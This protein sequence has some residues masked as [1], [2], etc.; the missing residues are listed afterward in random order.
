MPGM[1]NS[2]R[3]DFRRYMRLMDAWGLHVVF[4]RPPGFWALI[5]IRDALAVLEGRASCIWDRPDG[6]TQPNN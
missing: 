6:P 5:D 2:E 3:D 4:R 1:S